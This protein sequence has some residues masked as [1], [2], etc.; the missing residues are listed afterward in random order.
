MELRGTVLNVVDFG[1]FVDV[2]L[3]DSGLVHISQLANRFIR[4]PHEVVAVGD[5]VTVWVLKVDHERHRVSLTMIRPGTERKQPE[6][7]EPP[8]RRGQEQHQQGVGEQQQ[9]AGRGQRGHDRRPPPRRGQRPQQQQHAA[10]TAEAGQTAEG[11]QQQGA[12]QEAAARM[13]RRP[14]PRR[15]QQQGQ[16]RVQY[17]PPKR[18][19]VKPKLSEEALEGNAPLR[20]FAELKAYLD[21]KKQE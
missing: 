11:E 4:S 17:Q 8:Q 6:R 18:E 2:G 15:H 3:K 10:A 20:T 19:P 21:A 1:A 16:Q 12:A 9:G 13:Q 7:R 14:P 5:V